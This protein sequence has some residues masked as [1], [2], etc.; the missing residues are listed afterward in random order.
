MTPPLITESVVEEATISWLKE[1]G[2]I[3]L[4]GP[5]IAPGELFAERE[6]YG[7]VIL[8]NRLRSVLAKIN[9]NIPEEAREEAIRK[10]MRAE[11]PSLIEN[12]RRFH[13]YLVDGVPVEY[14][15]E[16]RSLLS[17]STR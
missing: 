15:K 5:D 4:F 3:L 14:Q 13:R 12:N 2:Y 6:S 11:H 1:L 9:P 17:T 7:E 8:I 16:N 10:V